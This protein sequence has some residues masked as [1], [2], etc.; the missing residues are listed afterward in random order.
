MHSVE[1]RRD[2]GGGAERS[3][4]QN[5]VRCARR[6][7][8]AVA[9]KNLAVK[10]QHV[11]RC[12]GQRLRHHLRPTQAEHRAHEPQAEA[13]S[14]AGEDALHQRIR[15]TPMQRGHRQLI[16]VRQWGVGVAADEQIQANAA[17]G[18]YSH[19]VK[20]FL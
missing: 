16:A 7:V 5:R 12:I 10:K 19:L 15:S 17:H 2:V 4:E 18:S 3:E 8:N 11:S 1:Q 6:H 20:H 9:A 13:R 14:L